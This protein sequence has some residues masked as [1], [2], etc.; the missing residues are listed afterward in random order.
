MCCVSCD[1]NPLVIWMVRSTIYFRISDG[2]SLSGKRIGF[3]SRDLLYFCLFLGYHKLS[4]KFSQ[5]PS[6]KC[7]LVSVRLGV[8][9]CK[10]LMYKYTDIYLN[11]MKRL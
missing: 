3:V 4:A 1:I 6:L 11:L 9:I 5:M 7:L 10:G 2:K 8:S